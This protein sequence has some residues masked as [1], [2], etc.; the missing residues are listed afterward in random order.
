MY[1]FILFAFLIGALFSGVLYEKV[2]LHSIRLNMQHKGMIPAKDNLSL[3][4]LF[5]LLFWIFPVFKYRHLGN[6]EHNVKAQRINY[7]LIGL[8][9]VGVL[10]V[11]LSK[12]VR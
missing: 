12:Y 8:F 9:L 11:F 4:L 5:N 2:R 1:I 10:F 3:V 6:G 7:Y